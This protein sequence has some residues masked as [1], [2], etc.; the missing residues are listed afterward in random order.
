M[1]QDETKLTDLAARRRR[2]FFY[3]DGFNL[4]HR[5]LE[6]NPDLKWLCLRTLAA[7][8]FP[9]DDISKV[10]FF[11]A[12]VDPA[13]TNSPKQRRQLN[14]WAALKA[15]G[16]QVI[17]GLLEKRERRCRVAQCDK[18][19]WF[20]T[21]SEKMSDVNLALHVYRDFIEEQPDVICVLSGDL[22]V[23]PA[24]KMIRETKRKVMLVVLLPTQDDGLLF[25]RQPQ[26][27]QVARVTQLSESFLKASRLPEQ[28]PLSEGITLFCPETWKIMA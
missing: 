20:S 16:V 9:R 26:H 17:E 8:F 14:Y 28:L 3:V 13:S 24:L 10:K 7:K 12:K 2:V 22:D 5:R 25:S 21:M 4:Y 19:G 1:I 18:Q 27:Y 6:G 11:T 15:R 23:L